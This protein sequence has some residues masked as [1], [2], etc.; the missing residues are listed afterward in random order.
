MAPAR[1]RAS[2]PTMANGPLLPA[3]DR[4]RGTAA[5]RGPEQKEDREWHPGSE[6]SGFPDGIAH[7]IKPRCQEQASFPKPDHAP[8]SAPSAIG[9]SLE[10]MRTGGAGT[11]GPAEVAC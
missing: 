7:A 2:A 11:H 5:T 8:V 3:T 9:K 6:D 1:A 10:T 4:G